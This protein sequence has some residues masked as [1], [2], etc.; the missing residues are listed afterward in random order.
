VNFTKAIAAS[1]ESLL[2]A[3]NLLCTIVGV[4]ATNWHGKVQIGLAMD[5]TGWSPELNIGAGAIRFEVAVW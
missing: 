2:L 1:K 5:Y 4:A 3:R